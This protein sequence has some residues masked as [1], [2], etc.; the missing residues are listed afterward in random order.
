MSS[1]GEGSDHKDTEL[2]KKFL[3]SVLLALTINLVGITWWAATVHRDLEHLH[4]EMKKAYDRHS[5]SDEEIRRIRESIVR[6][7]ARSLPANGRQ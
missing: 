7:E 5:R 3:I 6:L 4:M 1:T 2:D